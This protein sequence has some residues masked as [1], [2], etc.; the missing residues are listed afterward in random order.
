MQLFGITLPLNLPTNSIL[1]SILTPFIILDFLY[2]SY[3]HKAPF[4]S[5]YEL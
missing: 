4:S 3:T 2:M 1:L 5:D